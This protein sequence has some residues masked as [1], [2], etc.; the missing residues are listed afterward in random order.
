MATIDLSRLNES[1]R[2]VATRLDEPLF[3]AA[4]AGSGKTFTL[5]ARLV[6]ALSM[7]SAADGGRFL[8]SIDQALV[9]TFTKAA[10][11]EI[12]ER[13]RGALRAAGEEDPY[14]REESF[15]V[16]GAWISTIHGM[17]A[18][19]LRRHAIELGVDPEF[20]ICEDSVADALLA[21][22]L[23]QVLSD[24]Q[25]DEEHA[26]LRSE[27][28]LWGAGG[29]AQM[30]GQ[31]RTEAAKCAHG[32][33]DLDWPTSN[34]TPA[35]MA[36]LLDAL[37]A[38]CSFRLTAKQ[39]EAAH[40]ARDAVAGFCASAPGAQTAA[41]A[42]AVLPDVKPPALRKADQK[43][44]A[45]EARRLADEALVCAQYE[46]VQ[47]FVPQLVELARR[48]DRRYAQ[49]KLERSY[50]DNDDLIDLALGAVTRHP[51]VARDYA[52]RFKLVMI[53][54]FQ[55][56]DAKQLH[57]IELLEGAG[58]RHLAT[59]GDAQQAIYRFRGGDVEVFRA[60]GNSLPEQ[61]HVRMD[62][63]YRSDPNV[64]ACVERVC[65]DTGMLPDFL[66]LA[67]DGGRT[68]RLAPRADASRRIMLEVATGATA[69]MLSATLAAQLADRL[70]AYHAAG[71]PQGSMALLLGRTGKVRFYLDALRAR[72]LN[73]VVTGG[74]S[75]STTPEVGVVQALLYALANPH[76]TQDGLFRLLSSEMF[77]LDSDDF[78]MLG[79]RRQD[80]LDAPTKRPIERAFVDGT[81][82]LYGDALPSPRLAVAYEVLRRAFARIGRWQ[83]ADV[84]Q[85]VVDESGWLER[86]E[87]QGSDG[88][89]RAANVLAAVR[90]VRELTVDLGLGA[91]RAASEFDQ[92]LLAAKTTPKNLSGDQMD[93]VRVMTVH[94]SKGLQF[95]VCAVAECWGNAEVRGSLLVGRVGEG[96]MVCLA[97]KDVSKGYAKARKAFEVPASERSCATSAD[98]AV[99]LEAQELAAQ[100]AEKA[101]LL[102]VAL[103]RAEEALVVGIPV[104]EKEY[105]RS[106]LALQTCAAYLDPLDLEAG[107]S[108]MDIAPQAPMEVELRQGERIVRMPAELGSGVARVV[109]LQRPEKKGEPWTASSGGTLAGFDGALPD[110]VW[111]L[112]TLGTDGAVLRDS[113][114]PFS[115]YE[116]VC[117]QP[118]THGWRP[119][120]DVYSYSSV[121][122]L[123]AS[124]EQQDSGRRPP[125]PPLAELEAQA[126]GSAYTP[127]A[128][129]ATSLGSAFHEL[130]QTMVETRRDHDPARLEALVRTWRLSDRAAAR[131]RAA[132][133]RWERSAL[134]REVWEWPL[135]RAEVPFFVQAHSAYGEY[136][137]GAID[138]LATNVQATSALVVDYKTGDAG[139]S[140]AEI[141]E[142]HRMQAEFYAGVLMD[143]GF[144]YVEC[145][146]ACVEREDEAGEPIVVRY[147]FS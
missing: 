18:R 38:V 147:T 90:Y 66:K 6:H 132:V 13:V 107:E 50:L 3:V 84:C 99:Y 63:N 83:L 10:A 31:L 96:R 145:A 41:A 138:L 143:Q 129:K 98:W 5:T 114:L 30:I 104:A 51:E 11:L 117:D 4:G 28:S 131:L 46:R 60:H 102:Y 36:R 73:A 93:A 57:L 139:L 105:L 7:G 40:A 136:L 115:L 101:R 142:R 135:V 58:G 52:G 42:C 47:S 134:R 130:A 24:V 21:R 92:W 111:A 69:D 9:I 118:A 86:L 144:G 35:H 53:D 49:L 82:E 109:C 8:D 1:Q 61:A 79:T 2:A 74:S 25:H 19:I 22:A 17:C 27:Y 62:V 15:K 70:A 67:A 100:S 88:L 140:V 55:D 112:S 80:K 146:F 94:G 65:G 120:E 44:L 85:A 72:G 126:E 113:A 106:E 119:R 33:D 121:Q 124:R 34:Q 23:D 14:L 91:A 128:D 97:P 87:A 12:A 29:I 76:D 89:A 32:L 123:K 68:S 77:C 71:Q 127:D 43:P 45:D 125:T 133:A 54:E 20:S 116:V 81:L 26:A 37:E 141:E 122:A 56:T 59:V 39:S 137:E 95:G 64:L 103:T 78:C 75:F 16:D 108:P 110:S 48:V